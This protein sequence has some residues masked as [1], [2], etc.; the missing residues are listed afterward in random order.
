MDPKIIPGLSFSH[1]HPR[2]RRGNVL[3]ALRPSRVHVARRRGGDHPRGREPRGDRG[4]ARCASD[5]REHPRGGGGRRIHGGRGRNGSE[6]AAS[7]VATG[8]RN[9]GTAERREQK[10]RRPTRTLRGRTRTT[11]DNGPRKQRKFLCFRYGDFL[12]TCLRRHR[13]SAVVRVCPQ[14]PRLSAFCRSVVPSFRRSVA[15]SFRRSV[16]PPL[17]RS[18]PPPLRGRLSH[19]SALPFNRRPFA[20]AADQRLARASES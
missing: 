11:P 20:V 13:S 9:D 12:G 3:P 6:T 18:A 7:R 15:P 10:K 14:C 4:G 1:D 2:A 5:G 8:Q 19:E 17:R 16:V